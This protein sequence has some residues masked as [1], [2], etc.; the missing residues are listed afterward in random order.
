YF[1]PEKRKLLL[2]E[3][4][5]EKGARIDA[6]CGMRLEIHQVSAGLVAAGPEEMIEAHFEQIG[7]GSVAGDMA[8]QF[9]IGSIGAHH[10]RQGVPAND[11]GQVLLYLERIRTA[12][13]RRFV[14]GAYGVLVWRVARIAP[15]QS[16]PSGGF[17]ELGH[18]VARPL[19]PGSLYHAP[20]RI[21]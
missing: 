7:R 3:G 12:R 18:Q 2:A 8:A 16:Q 10:H 19:G 14:L 13:K 17:A 11:A 4:T 6:R 20:Q 21:Q 5:L 15:L 1:L 9:A